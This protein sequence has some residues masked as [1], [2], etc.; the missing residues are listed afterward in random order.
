MQHKV[1]DNNW[2]VIGEQDIQTEQHSYTLSTH[3]MHT[4]NLGHERMFYM[5]CI[6]QIEMLFFPQSD[7]YNS[8]I[9]SR[10]WNPLKIIQLFN[11][12][13]IQPIISIMYVCMYICMYVCMYVC[14]HMCCVCLYVYVN[15]KV[16][17]YILH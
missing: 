15:E 6:I 13:A 3:D 16:C 14:V 8:R 12:N 2:L 11:L 17:V 10:F 4:Y 7:G 9:Y 1:E 5:K